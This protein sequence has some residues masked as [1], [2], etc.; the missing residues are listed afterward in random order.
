MISYGNQFAATHS[1]I[2]THLM[3]STSTIVTAVVCTAAVAVA[4]V[5]TVVDQ[6]M[7]SEMALAVGAPRV[8]KP[9]SLETVLCALESLLQYK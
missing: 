6:S 4:V 2:S 7:I 8:G 5:Q 9:G 1:N 3:L